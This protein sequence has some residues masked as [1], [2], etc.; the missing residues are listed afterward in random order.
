MATVKYLA[1]QSVN[2]SRWSSGNTLDSHTNGSGSTPGAALPSLT[3]VTILH[4]SVKCA[5]TSKQWVTAVEACG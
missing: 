3:L 2:G 5:A 4:W 1:S